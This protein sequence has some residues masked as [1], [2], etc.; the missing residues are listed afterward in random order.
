MAG[1]PKILDRVRDVLAIDETQIA[2]S[3]QVLRERGNMSSATVPHVWM[4]I[5]RSREVEAGRECGINLEG[6]DKFEAGDVIE[7]FNVVSVRRTLTPS[8]AG[9]SARA[10]GRA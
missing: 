2:H 4:E 8:G 6:F 5:A 10:D 1:G 7:C 3:R 9:E